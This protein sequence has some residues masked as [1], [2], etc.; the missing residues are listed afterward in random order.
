MYNFIA[1]AILTGI[2]VIFHEFGHFIAA[3]IFGVEITR[4]SIG[5]GKR[6]YGKKIGTT[7][8]CL[9]M[10]PLGGYIKMTGHDPDAVIPALKQ[11]ESFTH[12]P[13]LRRI[14][15]VAAGP[16]FNFLLAILIL[17]GIFTFSGFLIL[18]PVIGNVVEGSPA[19]K[20]GLQGNDEI[21]AVED[22]FV[23]NWFEMTE[24]I[25][26]CQGRTIWL[27]VQREDAIYKFDIKPELQKI[28]NQFN[29]S[30]HRHV[31]GI[32]AS[33]K[34]VTEKLNP[35][36][37]LHQSIA[38]TSSMIIM[39]VTAIAKMCSGQ[40]SI[41]VLSGPF[42]IAQMAGS[43][44]QKGFI[45]FLFLMAGLSASLGVINLF[46]IPVFD[47][48]HLLF[49]IIEMITGRPVSMRFRSYAYKTGILFITI[50]MMFVC[51]KDM[52]QLFK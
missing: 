15:I 16:V 48:G 50:I 4:F 45:S 19:Y 29:E 9:S 18:K 5:F 3:K 46:P 35:L 39:N 31:I 22:R 51:I 6:I 38:R 2:I 33:G 36:S 49:F 30:E 41:N 10:I 26:Q 8:Y 14:L 24:A 23:K 28:Q 32:T 7:D 47:G 43:H 11:K 52:G 1:F 13:V 44:A 42:Q 21:I 20:S 37:A 27:A 25:N 17:I 34:T 40:M 12:Q